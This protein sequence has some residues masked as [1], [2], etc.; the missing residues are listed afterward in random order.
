[1]GMIGADLPTAQVARVRSLTEMG[2]EQKPLL[3]RSSGWFLF[4]ER[5]FAGGTAEVS[6]APEADV[7]AAAAEKMSPET[8]DLIGTLRSPTERLSVSP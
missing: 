7:L 4:N 1:M 8:R 5:T 6:N 3:S 2:H